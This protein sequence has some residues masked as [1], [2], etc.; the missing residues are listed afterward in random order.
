MKE[1]TKDSDENANEA[2]N[3]W[4]DSK[5]YFADVIGLPKRGRRSNIDE[6]KHSDTEC[7][8]RL[9]LRQERIVKQLCKEHGISV[10]DVGRKFFDEGMKLWINKGRDKFDLS[11]KVKKIYRETV[12]DSIHPIV[13]QVS[14]LHDKLDSFADETASNFEVVLVQTGTIKPNS[15]DGTETDNL[16]EMLLMR[17]REI[18]AQ[19]ELLISMI[20]SIL[21]MTPRFQTGT[22]NDTKIDTA[23]F[24]KFLDEG[25]EK[26]RTDAEKLIGETVNEKA[27]I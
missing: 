19:N 6:E 5:K 24:N 11:N 18:L 15:T 2:A 20:G 25:R 12:E 27:Q 14:L 9:N 13:S 3:F 7:R 8:F 23:A 4:G 16:T 22:G 21:K 10:Q 1:E 17:E 26:A